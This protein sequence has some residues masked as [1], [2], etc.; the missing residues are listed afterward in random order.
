MSLDSKDVVRS[1][2][3]NHNEEPAKELLSSIMKSV[4]STGDLVA[5]TKLL[6]QKLT[7]KDKD[8]L[9][10]GVSR[11]ERM[12]LHSIKIVNSYDFVDPKPVNK[13]LSNTQD[14]QFHL[15]KIKEI[16]N[17]VDATNGGVKVNHSPFF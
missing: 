13:M 12:L 16:L 14:V 10:I 9:L 1:I 17:K 4:L 2:E 8:L 7:K 11:T 6:S 5:M 15:N 3:Q